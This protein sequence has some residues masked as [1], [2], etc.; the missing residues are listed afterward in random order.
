MQSHTHTHTLV[1]CLPCHA[2]EIVTYWL[3]FLQGT[4][5]M[6]PPSMETLSRPCSSPEWYVF[7]P[8]PFLP[9]IP[10]DDGG[11]DLRGSLPK[12][13]T[14]VDWWSI[15]ALHS[16]L[17]WFYIND[18]E[19]ECCVWPNDIRWDRTS[20]VLTFPCSR[21]SVSVFQLWTYVDGPPRPLTSCLLF[22]RTSTQ[23]NPNLDGNSSHMDQ[24]NG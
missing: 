1:A 15:D 24:W 16:K 2:L 14:K 18:S 4:R 21:L 7:P 11:D 9:V 23:A 20:C 5:R 12:M 10:S 3:V 19:T 13:P 8:A 6:T 22:F 17:V